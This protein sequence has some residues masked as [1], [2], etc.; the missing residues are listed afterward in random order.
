MIATPMILRWESP[1]HWAMMKAQAYGCNR[2]AL[3]M[4]KR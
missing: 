2:K 4:I 1:V 3:K